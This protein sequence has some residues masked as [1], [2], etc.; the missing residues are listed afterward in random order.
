MV[1]ERKKIL[2]VGAS[3]DLAVSLNETLY[4]SGNTVGFHYNTND[5]PLSKYDEGEKVKKFQKDINSS[6]VC[7]QL[8]DDF[9]KWAG[10]I[11]CLIQLSGGIKKPANWEELTEKEWSYDLSVNMTMPFFLAQR[12]ILHMKNSGGRIVM[13]ST[14]SAAHGGGSTSLAYGVAKAGV[15]CIIKGL[16]R[17]CAKYNILVNAIAPGFFLTKFHTEKMERTKEQ[18]QERIKLIPLRRAGT[19]EELAGTVMYLLSESASYITGQV[20][21]ISGGD[22]L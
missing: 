3:S 7:F 4:N 12:A 18:V 1:L 6:L 20:I 8:V 14:V 17:D 13:T 21:A 22:W 15:E 16:A 19:T 11:D 10:G 5:K 2:I 9:V